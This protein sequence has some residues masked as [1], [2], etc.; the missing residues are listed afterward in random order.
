MKNE[1]RH[2]RAVCLLSRADDLSHPDCKRRHGRVIVHDTESSLGC[3]VDLSK[4]G[5]RV[6]SK[7]AWKPSAKPMRVR[8]TLGED[9][10][11]VVC[12]VAWCKRL[13]L[14]KHEVGI[15][16]GDLSHEEITTIT[17]MARTA[18]ANAQVETSIARRAS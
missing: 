4:S 5:M 2:I 12:R 8:V 13:S 6:R 7:K 17:R 16:F 18:A 14:W 11:A 1:G 3:V 15:E 10:V 9:S